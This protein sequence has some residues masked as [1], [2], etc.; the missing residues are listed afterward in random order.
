MY[1]HVVQIIC[2]IVPLINSSSSPPSSL[3]PR[4]PT[5]PLLLEV[6]RHSPRPD[7]HMIETYLVHQH[8][9]KTAVRPLTLLFVLRDNR[10]KLGGNVGIFRT[11]R[12]VVIFGA[13][14]VFSDLCDR[15]GPSAQRFRQYS[16]HSRIFRT[17]G[18]LTSSNP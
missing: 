4:L 18:S 10:L 6:F 3:H 1:V 2:R 5:S 16:S 13:V 11:W 7:W 12:L 15:A 14:T 9:S 17:S 8:D